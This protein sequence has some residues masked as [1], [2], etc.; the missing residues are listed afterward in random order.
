MCHRAATA[1]ADRISRNDQRRR[2][3]ATLEFI[4]RRFDAIQYVINQRRIVT[5]SD[6]LFRRRHASQKRIVA[7]TM[8]MYEH[9]I[10]DP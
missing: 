6:D 2:Q 9:V 5:G 4:R 7:M 3:L 8:Q 1:D 10:D